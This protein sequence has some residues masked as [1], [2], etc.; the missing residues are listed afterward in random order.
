MRG[1]HRRDTVFH[2]S[3]RGII[4][5]NLYCI[6]WTAVNWVA[7]HHVGCI[8]WL[9]ALIISGLFG[10]YATDVWPQPKSQETDEKLRKRQETANRRYQIWFN[11]T[12][13]IVGWIVLWILICRHWDYILGRCATLNPGWSDLLM[14]FIAFIGITGHLP[15]TAAGIIYSLGDIVKKAAGKLGS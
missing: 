3:E 12:G 2:G 5:A 1:H 14:G 4:M 10:W 8:F 11:F 15:W 6:F 9:I 7:V 13:S